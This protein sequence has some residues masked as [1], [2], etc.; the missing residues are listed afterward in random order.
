MTSILNLKTKKQVKKITSVALLGTVCVASIFSVKTFARD[1]YVNVDN[2]TI[3]SLTIDNNV[4]NILSKVGVYIS[5]KDIVEKIDEPE[6]PLK[7]NVKRAFD[8]QVIDGAKIINM[9]ATDGTVLDAFE[10]AGIRLGEYDISSFSL[11]SKLTKDMKILITRRTKIFISAD[12]EQKQC[13]V[14]TGISVRDA[15]KYS[16]TPL[17]D[18][19]MVNLNLD[20]KVVSNMEISISRIR[21]EE[22]LSTESI[23]RNIVTKTS[24][25][26]DKGTEEVSSE[27]KDG[28]K[29]IRTIQTFKD[30]ELIDSQVISETVIE[31]PVDKVIIKGTRAKQEPKSQK[32]SCAEEKVSSIIYGS[33][34]AYTAPSGAR[35][36][37]GAIPREGVTVA[38]NPKKIPYGS[39]ILIES[40]DGSYRQVLTAQDTGGALRKG[41]AIADIYMNSHSACRNFGR[42]QVKVSILS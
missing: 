36:S 2:T 13:I 25:L 1:V 16:K 22:T 30:N 12:G 4:D 28:V 42:K 17:F 26:M 21:H 14:P 3:H 40:C 38:V 5:D 34:T 29:E 32:N 35:T 41:T 19:D 11:N 8:F 39:K 27:G 24:T 18:E 31:N 9:Q 23:P 10:S 6:Q 15:L 37:T 7:L 33:A 20:E